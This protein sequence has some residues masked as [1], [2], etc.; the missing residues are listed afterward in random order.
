MIT[1]V[2]SL[3][4]GQII[5]RQVKES[6]DVV[7]VLSGHVQTASCLRLRLLIRW[8][9]SLLKPGRAGECKGGFI[10]SPLKPGNFSPSARKPVV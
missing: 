3:V 1:L 5:S 2:L 10:E 7:F 8:R 6:G 9:F 4:P